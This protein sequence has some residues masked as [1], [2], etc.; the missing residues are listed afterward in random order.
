MRG[1]RPGYTGEV[2][3]SPEE[4]ALVRRCAAGD[5]Q[6]W[7]RLMERYGALVAHAV[8]RTFERV[9]GRAEPGQVDDAIQAVWLSL[10][11]DGGRRLREFKGNSALSTWLTV[12]ST[13]RALDALRTERRKGMLRHVRLDGEDRDLAGELRAPEPEERPAPDEI[14]LLHE[15]L[16]RLPPGDRLILKLYYLDGLS[17]GSIATM[18]RLAPNTISSYLLRAREKL[19]KCIKEGAAGVPW[20]G[21]R[22]A[23]LAGGPDDRGTS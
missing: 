22:G 12:L 1:G 19:K 9:L 18:L 23:R 3:S 5:A 2:A 15:A 16:E 10:C 4:I 21:G 17:Y 14:A 8:R 20:K 7:R 11:A 13:R 6:A